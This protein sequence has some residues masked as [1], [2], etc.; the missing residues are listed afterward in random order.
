MRA[1]H[2]LLRSARVLVALWVLIAGASAGRASAENVLVIVADDLGVDVLQCYGEGSTFPPTPT[3]D[4]FCENGIL[5]RNAWSNPV[6]STSRATI[7]TGRYSFRTGVGD[8]S[9]QAPLSFSEF[10]IPEALDLNPELGYAHAAIGKWHLS[11]NEN[12][13]PD[14]PNLSGY[15]HFSGS[16]YSLFDYSVWPK[17]ENG[18][19]FDTDVYPTT[20][21]V[22]EAIEWINARG[23]EPWFLWLAFNAPHSPLHA[24]PD[25]LH[26]YDLSDDPTTLELFQAMVEAVDTEVARLL[27]SMAPNVLEKTNI[28][29][30]GDNGTAGPPTQPPFDPDHGKATLYEG[31]I[32]VPLIF[33]GPQV[34]APG[35]ESPALVNTTD[36]FATA[37]E[38]MGV[39]VQ[40]SLPPSAGLDSRSLV[41]ILHDEPF[42]P[43]AFVYAELF[44]EAEPSAN[45]G[46]AI[47]NEAG[48]K[49]IR[50][51]LGPEQM[52][53][54]NADPFEATDLL[55]AGLN[56]DQQAHYDELSFH[57]DTIT[58]SACPGDANSDGTV[59]PLDSGYVLARLGCPVGAGNSRCDAADQNHDGQVNPL[60]A[61]YV[62]ARLGACP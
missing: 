38:L 23:D 19:A 61:G 29:F 11:N 59:D 7:Q 21:N 17:V 57:L 25:E 6:C 14:G 49:L 55:L 30:L 12:G 35:R 8:F 22:N 26:S 37:L 52:Y 53:D 50:Y 24:P 13:G 9:Q 1:G 56:P 43:R 16:L 27:G 28:I 10:I 62:L 4:T 20:D 15:S 34:V 33:S 3:I 58:H 45:H 51:I 36:L 40:A 18:E 44:R 5:F 60:D 46:Q 48:Y 41:P 47:R 31:G 32:N 39:D 54:L 2:D 42:E